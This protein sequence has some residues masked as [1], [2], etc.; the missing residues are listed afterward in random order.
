MRSSPSSRRTNL[1][2]AGMVGMGDDLTAALDL[3]LARHET[4]LIDLRR[5]LHAHPEPAYAERRTTRLV[6]DRLTAA[7]RRP[8]LLPESTGL[9][10]DV[11]PGEPRVALRA[12]LD[13]LPMDDEKCVPYRSTIRGMCHSCGHDAHTAM[14]VGTGLFLAEQAASELLPGGVRLIF[15]PAE[16]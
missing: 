14:L 2:S 1:S 12:D 5:D 4:E 9:Y 11:G 6:A 7:G 13:A 16:E 10:A 15:Q 3:F 8:V